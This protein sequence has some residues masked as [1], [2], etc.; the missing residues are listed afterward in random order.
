[1]IRLLRWIIFTAVLASGVHWVTV[2]FAP[3]MIMSRVLTAVER[4]SKG[5]VAFG[6]RPTAESRQVVRPSPDLLYSTCVFDVSRSPLKITT[7]APT[8][9]YWSVALYGDNSDNFF[10]LNDSQA[11][12]QPATIILVG[13]GQTVPNLPPGVIVVSAPST[14]GL[15]LFRTLI[16]DDARLAEIDQQRRQSRCDTILPNELK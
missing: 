7:A 14:R 5:G 13:Q 8:D 6:E 16:I 10:V 15:V 3:G 1:M 2:A 4:N 9:T 11:N 12:G